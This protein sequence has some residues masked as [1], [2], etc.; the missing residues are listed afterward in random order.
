MPVTFKVAPHSAVPARKSTSAA[1]TTEDLLKSAACNASKS[2][3]EVLQ[4]SID[5]FDI[6]KISPSPNGF[7]YACINAYNSHQ[8]LVIRP[9]DIWIAILTQFSMYV[10]RHAEEL[11]SYFVAHEGK[12]ELVVKSG[13]NRYTVDFGALARQMGDLLD[14]RFFLVLVY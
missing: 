12:K 6:P 13:G 8:N 1:A 10:N 3:S 2:C 9:D 4:S 5:I 14:V 11:R 7:V